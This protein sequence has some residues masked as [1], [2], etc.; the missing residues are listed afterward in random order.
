MKKRFDGYYAK[1]VSDDGPVGVVVGTSQRG[2][3][4]KAFLQIITEHETFNLEFDQWVRPRYGAM[5]PF[6]FC[7]FMQCRHKVVAMRARANG[8]IKL[9]GR[10][11]N[12]ENADGY[13]EG[14]CGKSFPQKYFWTQT[15]MDD[16][17]IMASVAKIPYLGMRFTGTI[18]I[19]NAGGREYRLA[20]YLGARVRVF[21]ANMVVVKQWRTTLEITVENATNMHP[22][23][24]PDDGNMSRTIHESV[25]ATVR[26]K[27]TR[28]KRVVFDVVSTRAAYEYAE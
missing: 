4:K 24:A 10:V 9:G 19:I 7:P 2:H 21:E 5:G 17:S 23:N 25:A 15:H 6:R 22:L 28:G 12:F 8:T 13:I 16:L 18:C 26:Y 11:Y 3:N 27:M 20:T 14:D 1:A